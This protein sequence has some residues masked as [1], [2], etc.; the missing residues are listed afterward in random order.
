MSVIYISRMYI[1]VVLFY[2]LLGCKNNKDNELKD[3]VSSKELLDNW[4]V[5]KNDSITVN[6]PSSWT[7]K[8]EKDLLLYIPLDSNNIKS[9]FAIL[10][11]STSQISYKDYLKEIFKQVSQKDKKFTYLIKKIEFTNDS[12]CHTIE[13]FVEEDGIKYKIYSLL[14]LK[15]NQIYDFSYK[16]I[17]EENKNINN[18]KI[19][20]TLIFSLKYYDKFIIDG[21][22]FIIK[23][24]SIIEY[25][26]I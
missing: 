19:F 3:I 5:F 13:L 12:F 18:Y 9:Y 6:I 25:D 7:P 1:I 22:N 2:I 15:N 11:N 20:Y 8:E 4:K 24:Q 21:E 14:Y 16:A 17:N 10:K 26:E 23:E